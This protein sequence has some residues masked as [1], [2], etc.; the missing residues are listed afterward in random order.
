MNTRTTK[1]HAV[2]DNG[3]VLVGVKSKEKACCAKAGD[4]Q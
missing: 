1:L 4:I 3:K 2:N